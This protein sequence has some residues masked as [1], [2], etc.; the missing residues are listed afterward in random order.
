MKIEYMK[1]DIS[2][3]D[4]V[5]AFDDYGRSDNFS[6]EARRALYDYLTDMEEDTGEETTLDVIALCCEFSEYESAWEAMQQ[7]QPDDM[8]CEGEESD[9]LVEI[10]EKNEA[11]ALEWL[12][13][14]TTVIEVLGGGV[15]I[16]AF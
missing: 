13:D 11:A 5:R 7:Y 10:T 2:Q 8:P 15:V 1:K 3:C 12:Q 6:I 16:A 14:R 9:D 4:F